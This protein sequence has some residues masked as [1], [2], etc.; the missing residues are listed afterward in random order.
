MTRFEVFILRD[1]L[2]VVR[3]PL[4]SS[5]SSFEKRLL[6][7]SLHHHHYHYIFKYLQLL[8][9]WDKPMRA[10]FEFKIWPLRTASFIARFPH[11]PFFPSFVTWQ[12]FRPLRLL[13]WVWLQPLEDF[14]TRRQAC[15]TSCSPNS[16]LLQFVET[17]LRQFLMPESEEL[18]IHACSPPQTSNQEKWLRDSPS[19]GRVTLVCQKA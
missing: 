3:V 4:P 1:F 6:K 10:V 11:A 7:S 17:Q 14:Q 5:S 15:P 12:E 18:G 16:R 8:W 13:K 19:C 9:P 2:G